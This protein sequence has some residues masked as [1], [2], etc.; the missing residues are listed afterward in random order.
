[1][2][3]SLKHFASA[4]LRGEQRLKNVSLPYQAKTPILIN[5]GRDFAKLT[6]HCIHAKHKHISIK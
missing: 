2:S 5:A 3:F 1:M 4:P 6:V